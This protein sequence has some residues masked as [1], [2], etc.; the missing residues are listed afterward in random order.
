[1]DPK[2]NQKFNKEGELVKHYGF[3]LIAVADNKN[4]VIHWNGS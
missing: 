3:C 1:M 2:R 4:Y